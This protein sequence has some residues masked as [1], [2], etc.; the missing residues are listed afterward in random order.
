PQ[1]KRAV[2]PG[3]RLRV[4]GVACAPAPSGLLAGQKHRALRCKF[5]LPRG[6]RGSFQGQRVGGLCLGKVVDV[7]GG[8]RVPR[9]R[10][11]TFRRKN[12]PNHY[13][14]YFVA[15]AAGLAS[16]A[17]TLISILTSF[18]TM[19]P[20]PATPYSWRLIGRPAS[21]PS[22]LPRCVLTGPVNVNGKSTSLE[23]PWM[24]SVPCAT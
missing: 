12:I 19:R 17:S 5:G 15:G 24:V 4:P 14:S 11:D 10:S 20:P 18:Q 16:W 23:T 22:A 13:K 6:A 7:A 2:D 8:N 21:A 9:Q 1:Q 3:A